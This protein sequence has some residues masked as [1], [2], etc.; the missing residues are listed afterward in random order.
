MAKYFALP[1]LLMALF[2]AGCG[3][4]AATEEEATQGMDNVESYGDQMGEEEAPSN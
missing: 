3:Q 2:M 1:L 4:R